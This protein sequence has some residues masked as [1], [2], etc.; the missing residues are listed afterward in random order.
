MI[1]HGFSYHPEVNSSSCPDGH[2]KREVFTGG[3]TLDS[4]HGHIFCLEEESDR[5]AINWLDDQDWKIGEKVV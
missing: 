5:C 3:R 4:T 2:M 1:Q